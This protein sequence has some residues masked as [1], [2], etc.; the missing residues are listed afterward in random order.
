MASDKVFIL[1]VYTKK[2]TALHAQLLI[3]AD[4]KPRTLSRRAASGGTRY[5]FP[6]FFVGLPLAARRT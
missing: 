3:I 5:W 2:D 6:H 4:D 1:E